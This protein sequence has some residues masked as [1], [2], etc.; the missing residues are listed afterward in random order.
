MTDQSRK[1]DRLMTLEHIWTPRFAKPSIREA[2]KVKIARV[3][4]DFCSNSL[5]RSLMEVAGQ[6]PHRFC[7]LEV[8]RSN[9]TGSAPV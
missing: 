9:R 6:G 5:P 2:K 7:A 8:L 3:Y 4:P 1:L